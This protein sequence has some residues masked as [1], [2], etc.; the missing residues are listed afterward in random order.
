[1]QV[2]YVITR[3]PGEVKASVEVQTGT[4]EVVPCGEFE[5]VQQAMT[6]ADL[7][8]ARADSGARWVSE[9]VEERP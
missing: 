5:T 8:I 2:R 6:F 7:G 1:M 4:G 9:W 3:R